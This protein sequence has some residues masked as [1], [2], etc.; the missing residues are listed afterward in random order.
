MK[1]ISL[2]TELD[3]FNEFLPFW[4]V[5][6]PGKFV[7]ISGKTAYQFWDSYRDALQYA[8]ERFGVETP[9]MVKKIE[10]QFPIWVPAL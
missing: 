10:S 2:Q 5:S 7:V 6:N 1:N 3:T 8:Y 9:F 4:L